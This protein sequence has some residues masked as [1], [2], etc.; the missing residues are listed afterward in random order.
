M[1][2]YSKLTK[3]A[4][5]IESRFKAT[6]I[7]KSRYVP[8]NE[9]KAFDFPQLPV[10]CSANPSALDFFSWGLIPNWSEDDTIKKYTLN[11]RIETLE[12]K[13]SF[14]EFTENRCLIPANG[15]YEWKWLDSK[16]KFK[17]K[18][19]IG[20]KD[21]S[22]FSFAGIWSLWKDPVQALEI[23]TFAVLTTQADSLMSEIHNTKKR[24]PVILTQES[25]KH[26]LQQAPLENFKTLSPA[27]VA[28][29][30]FPASP[31][32]DLF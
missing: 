19:E 9:I 31:Q 5:E 13:A 22:L 17:E 21:E 4:E 30:I 26:W 14:R 28:K 20:L 11:A 23:H 1:C 25:E 18:Y 7:D 27:L 16:G 12:T 29:R 8:N 15:F 32:L 6:F 3:K 24:M 2:F 10:I